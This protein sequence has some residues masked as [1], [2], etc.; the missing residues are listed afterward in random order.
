MKKLRKM[1]LKEFREMT[2]SE[3]RNVV[4]GYDVTR[5]TCAAFI[6]YTNGRN[7]SL[8]NYDQHTTTYS[9]GSL[10]V[11]SVAGYTIHRGI[12]KESALGMTMGIAGAKWCCDN[13]A[14]ATWY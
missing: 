1:E 4:G 11:N 14:Y 13:C 7:P 3:M 9:A 6:P 10:E 2:D 5:G 8:G 12:S